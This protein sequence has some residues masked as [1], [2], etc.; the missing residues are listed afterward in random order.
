VLTA[1]AG[2]VIAGEADALGGDLRGNVDNAVLDKFVVR[3]A[4]MAGK[5]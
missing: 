2:D 3:H 1:H 4:E 5:T